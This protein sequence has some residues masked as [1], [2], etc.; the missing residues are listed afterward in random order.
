[1]SLFIQ[2]NVSSMVA[3]NNFASTELKLNKTMSELSSG[4]K[5]NSAAD[6]AAGL[7]IAKRLDAQVQSYSA[8]QSNATQGISMAQTADGGAEQISNVL[9]RL[10]Q[11]AVEGANGTLSSSDSTN[12]DQE[13]QA[14]MKD[15]DNISKVTTYNGQ[16]L[17]NGTPASVA[18]QTG[19]NQ[20]TGTSGQENQTSISFGGA[21]SSSLGLSGVAVDNATDAG[22]A[23]SAI[24]T[25]IQKLSTVRAGFGAAM[26]SMQTAVSNLQTQQTNTAA[27]LSSVQDVDVAQ[28][29]ADLARQQ[30]LAQAGESVLAQANQTTQLATNLI[31]GQ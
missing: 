8:A 21:D 6:D 16:N 5:I 23:I 11:L 20:N 18:F 10:R 19:I 3:Q 17:L 22:S 28:A 31:H 9:T 15:I 25:A 2:T 4:Y 24:D 26:N 13:F 29:T 1:M 30:V 14:A 12:L 27:S 7:G